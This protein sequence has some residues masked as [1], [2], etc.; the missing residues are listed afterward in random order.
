VTQAIIEDAFRRFLEGIS[1]RDVALMRAAADPE[2]EFTSYFAGVEAKTYRGHVSLSDYLSD[3]SVAWEYFRLT[4]EEFVP[5][6]ADTLV[7]DVHAEA[8]SRSGVEID[9]H[10]YGVWEFRDGKPRR[11]RTYGSREEALQAVGLSASGR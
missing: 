5:A 8:R 2:V 11:G 3:L 6:G 1:G 7:V 10:L 4:P 9:Q